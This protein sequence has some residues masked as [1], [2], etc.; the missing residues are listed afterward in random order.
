MKKLFVIAAVFMFGLNLNA[1][2][3]DDMV[4]EQFSRIAISPTIMNIE[5]IDLNDLQG[6]FAA[7]N[8]VIEKKGKLAET[9][10]SPFMLYLKYSF[11]KNMTINADPAQQID[12]LLDF[13]VVDIISKSQISNFSMEIN[14]Q[15]SDEMP[16]L[17][18]ALLVVS[19]EDIELQ[20]DLSMGRQ[21]IFQTHVAQC[22]E[23][24][25]AI[26]MKSHEGQYLQTI[27]ALLSISELQSECDGMSSDLLTE[28]IN[29]K[30]AFEATRNMETLKYSIESKSDVSEVKQYADLLSRNVQGKESLLEL[31]EGYSNEDEYLAV[32]KEASKAEP[33]QIDPTQMD[34]EQIRSIAK[35][36]VLIEEEEK[37]SNLIMLQETEMWL[38]DL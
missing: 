11:K 13:Y 7:M 18:A 3:S 2:E 26:Q 14:T 9:G 22:F 19:K 27:G 33:V 21:E 15:E 17:T 6:I 29:G 1:Q 30:N 24:M 20:K 35:E 16:A 32:L 36:M 37:V 8:V 34:T 5:Q 4:E 38:K 25:N 28:A 12:V 31:I 23:F 10:M